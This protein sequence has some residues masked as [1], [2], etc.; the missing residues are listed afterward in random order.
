M[1]KRTAMRTGST[2]NRLI[3]GLGLIMIA[4]ISTLNVQAQSREITSDVLTINSTKDYLEAEQLIDAIATELYKAHQQYPYFTYDIEYKNNRLFA[5]T[6]SGIDNHTI[7]NRIADQIII[8]EDVA[9]A[10]SNMDFNLLPAIPEMSAMDML[11]EQQASAYQ[12]NVDVSNGFTNVLYT[13]S[14]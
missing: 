13:A 7:A 1:R 2:T 4:F 9:K 5:V 3:V 8:L 6:V 11:N 10:V 14:N 12:P